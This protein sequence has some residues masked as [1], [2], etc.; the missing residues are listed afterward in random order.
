MSR[1]HIYAQCTH[2]HNYLNAV[3][4]D[5]LHCGYSDQ[6]R[7][8]LVHGLQFHLR[9]EAVGRTLDRK[10]GEQHTVHGQHLKVF[11]YNL[12]SAHVH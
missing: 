3:S 12:Q 7:T 9:L 11:L 2:K 4:L 5:L 10:R 6:T 1:T 8:S